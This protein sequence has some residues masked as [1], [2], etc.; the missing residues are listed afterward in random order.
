MEGPGKIR[1][2]FAGSVAGGRRAHAP[3]QHG[4]IEF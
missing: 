2:L 4:W 3:A 1:A